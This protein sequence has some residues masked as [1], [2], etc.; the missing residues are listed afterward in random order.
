MPH[1]S[2]SSVLCYNNHLTKD[3]N[4][5][6]MRRYRLPTDSETQAAYTRFFK[7]TTSFNWKSGYICAAHWS[8]GVR[9]TPSHLPDVLLPPGHFEILKTKYERAK[10]T[11]TSAAK[12]TKVQRKAYRNAKGKFEAAKAIRRSTKVVKRRQPPKPHSASSSTLNE[13]P[14]PIPNPPSSPTLPPT[15]SSSDHEEEIAILRQKLKEK[16]EKIKELEKKVYEK[17]RTIDQLRMEAFEKT[18]FTYEKISTEPEKVEYLTG[19]S[20][21]QFCMIID[22][23][24][25]YIQSCLK[26]D[27]NRPA[28]ERTFSYETQY[29]IVMMICR[30]GLDF[31]FAAYMTNVTAVTIGRIFN[32]WVVFLSTLFNQLDQRPHQ[33][34]LQKKMP[35]IFVKTGHGTTD[36]VLDATEFRFQTASNF[37]ISSLMFSHYK[38]TT[39]GKALIGISPHGMGIIFSEIY[40][41]SISDTE[42]TEKN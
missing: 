19:L 14:A 26:Y 36:L 40:P 9:E 31:K 1:W 8:S 24:R 6:K 20:V 10:S 21:E 42:I 17:S 32:G 25:P 34:F 38:N 23:V 35:E 33:K 39:T 7:T 3:G 37:D 18:S 4:N 29:L 5:E 11:F 30:H 28:T 15:T 41:G 13:A 27:D 16:D 12:P 2:C 22:C